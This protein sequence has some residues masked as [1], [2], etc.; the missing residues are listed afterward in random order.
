MEICKYLLPCRY[1]DK[2]DEPCKATT[3]DMI[4]Y[5]VLCGHISEEEAIMLNCEHEWK[6]I[7]TNIADGY[8]E[9]GCIKCGKTR[10][11]MIEAI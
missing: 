6:H 2:Y 3:E 1:C 7:I 8:E 11:V 9:H 5:N 10:K 4:N